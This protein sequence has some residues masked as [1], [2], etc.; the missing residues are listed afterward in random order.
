M[1]IFN[2]DKQRLRAR[3]IFYQSENEFYNSPIGRNIG[4][5]PWVIFKGTV[6]IM[7]EI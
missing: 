2:A 1:N 7:R 5:N 4:S 6:E 3:K